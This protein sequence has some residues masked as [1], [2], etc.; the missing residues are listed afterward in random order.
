MDINGLSVIL[1]LIAL[2]ILMPAIY[3]MGVS[4]GKKEGLWTQTKVLPNILA[5]RSMIPS[6]TSAIF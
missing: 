3:L 6:I 2:V 1:L 5:P 4:K